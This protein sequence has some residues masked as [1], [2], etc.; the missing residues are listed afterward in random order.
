MYVIFHYTQSCLLY[1]VL[2]AIGT[3][4]GSQNELCGC[5]AIF[6][7]NSD[8]VVLNIEKNGVT[9]EEGWHIKPCIYPPSVNYTR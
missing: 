9:T 3:Q 8:E 4:Y 7:D 6:D 5:E 1:F 2:Q